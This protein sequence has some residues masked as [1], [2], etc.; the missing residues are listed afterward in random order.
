MNFPCPWKT[1]I[2]F[3]AASMANKEEFKVVFV[4]NVGSGK[5][6]AVYSASDVDVA[7]TEARAS[8]QEALHRKPTTTVAMEYGQ[9]LLPQTRIHLYG[10]PGQRRFDFMAQVLCQGASGM[11]VLIDNGCRKPLQ[12]LD[13]YLN[14]HSAF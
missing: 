10:S 2:F 6:T 7:S 11:I 13:Y 1:G 4:G 5:T 3:N 8:E 14:F 9:M 12:E